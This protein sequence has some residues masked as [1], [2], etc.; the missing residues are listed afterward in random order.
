MD[1]VNGE[2]IEL[3]DNGAWATFTDERAV[4]DVSGGKLIVGSA[5][6][7]GARSGNLEAVI[8]DVATKTVGTPTALGKLG[9]DDHAAP[10]FLVRPDG[11]YL[12]YW[13]GRNVD[14][15][16][17]YRVYDAAAWAPQTIFDW[18]TG[19]GCAAS[20]TKITFSNPWHLSAEGKIYNFARSVGGNQHVSVSSDNGET[21]TYA[22]RLTA[23]AQS[24]YYKYWGNGVDRIDFV[25]TE[26]H[27]RDSDN[28]LY[29][30]YL[31]GGKTYDS[32]GKVIDE[33]LA[34]AMTPD[35]TAFSKAYTTGST[36]DGVTLNHAWNA[37]IVRYAD[38]TVV[39]LGLARIEGTGTDSPEHR[40]LYVRWDGKAWTTTALGK[41]GPK[42]YASEQDYTGGGTLHPDNPHK[43]YISTTIDP[44]DGTTDLVKHEIF[45]GTS[46]DDGATWS[47]IPITQNS[48]RENLRPSVPKW[49]TS[50]T[51]LV[52]FRGTYS[53]AQTY[54]ASVVGIVT[55]G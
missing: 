34:D 38:G 10:A 1:V 46:C 19:G 54:S 12:A 40:L 51:A 14:C 5:A 8:Y 39:I 48:T 17:Y 42:L 37:D 41:T 23:T 47:W 13:A 28:N 2:L 15:N 45:E 24:G 11:K 16:T 44:R 18:T 4:V 7:G 31:S 32:T 30:G 27:P 52:W 29:H 50:H 6:S 49:D 20:G 9:A 33:D 55:G 53:S 21:W 22:G 36:F 3:N 26:G 43:L 25:G 35:I